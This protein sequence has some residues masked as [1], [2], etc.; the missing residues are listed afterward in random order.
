MH[1]NLLSMGTC[2]AVKKKGDS[3]KKFKNVPD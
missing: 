2:P 3:I 1:C